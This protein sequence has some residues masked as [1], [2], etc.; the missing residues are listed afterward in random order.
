M[1]HKFD[2]KKFK[3]LDSAERRSI[4][5]PRETLLKLGLRKNDVFVDIGCGIGYFTIPALD[6]VGQDGRVYAIDTS[7][8]MLSELKKRVNAESIP[9]LHLIRTEEYQF[10]IEK[11]SVNFAFMSNVLH[12]IDDKPLFLTLIRDMLVDRGTVAIIEW[13]KRESGYGPPMK[14]RLDREN[15]RM[16][17]VDQGYGDIHISRMH[18]DFY[19]MVGRKNS[20]R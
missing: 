1:A 12:E 16:L 13:E 18:E 5:P 9:N 6:I 10:G 11:A 7:D 19:S 3:K 14:Y 2:P 4:M 20:I 8:K 17:L 15:L